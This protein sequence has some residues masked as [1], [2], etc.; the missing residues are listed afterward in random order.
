MQS[1]GGVR[2]QFR[3]II[4]F[5]LLV[6]T[7]I[8]VF[9][10]AP[11]TFTG[12]VV[13]V[14]DGDTIEV[15]HGGKGEKIRLHGIDCPETG[16]PFAS[17]AK[18]FT[19]DKCFGQEVTIEITDVDRYGRTVGN[20]ILPD[21]K[22]LNHEL[23]KNGLAWWYKQYASGDRKLSELQT[24]AMLA[25]IG[26]WGELPLVAPWDYRNGKT[27]LPNYTPPDRGADTTSHDPLAP[28][29]SSNKLRIK[30]DGE[31]SPPASKE[32]VDARFVSPSENLGTDV[33]VYVT[34]T[35]S[36]YHTGRCRYLQSKVPLALRDAQSRGYSPCSVCGPP[37]QSTSVSPPAG[38]S[39]GYGIDAGKPGARYPAS[40]A[41][42]RAPP[43]MSQAP[44]SMGSGE[45][46]YITNSGKKYHADGCRYLSKSKI[47]IEKDAAMKRGYGAC[48]VCGP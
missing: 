7:C 8:P 41:A 29:S 18:Q 43:S 16:Q 48:S 23:V 1:V 33:T 47:Q 27:H 21:G 12:Q 36:K 15:M 6:F 26:L 38:S 3:A 30:G 13:G 10:D 28:S 46:V 19:S 37:T 44:A 20:V 5:A 39:Y 34:R 40:S 24:K 32:E 22:T 11:S 2:N 25:E 35:G 45:T 31:Y 17:V 42:P 9:A 4:T 14:T